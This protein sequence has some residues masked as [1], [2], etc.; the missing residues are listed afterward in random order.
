MT[1]CPGQ[2]WQSRRAPTRTSTMMRHRC[3]VDDS[4]R[5]DTETMA[6]RSRADDMVATVADRRRKRRLG[7]ANSHRRLSMPTIVVLVATLAALLAGCTLGPDYKR[8]AVPVP[9]Q[10]R[11]AE[12][13]APGR[14][15]ASLADVQWFALFQDERLQ[16][17]VRTALANNY[18]VRI[19]A[20]PVLEDAA[21][22]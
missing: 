14:E 19:A 3:G 4:C 10:H 6:E 22:L 18:D 20:A 9:A 17:L 21:Q 16:A 12:P 8:P 11:D 7:R 1:R 2:R 15:T 13:P 5:K